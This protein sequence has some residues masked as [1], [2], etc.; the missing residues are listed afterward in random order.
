MSWTSDARSASPTD[1]ER[2]VGQ[3][4]SE[5]EFESSHQ[6]CFAPTPP[7]STAGNGRNNVTPALATQKPDKGVG[8]SGM[9]KQPARPPP[10]AGSPDSR[11]T[12]PET[13]CQS[14]NQLFH[15][16]GALKMVAWIHCQERAGDEWGNEMREYTCKECFLD[17][18]ASRAT[19]QRR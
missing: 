8:K 3:A 6:R 13:E 4:R 11:A 18:E 2:G 17:G 12:W 19:K 7:L 1:S 5:A 16:R 15:R 14:C 10:P 9:P